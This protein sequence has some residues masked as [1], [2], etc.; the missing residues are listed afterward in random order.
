MEKFNTKQYETL[1]PSIAQKTQ[2]FHNLKKLKPSESVMAHALFVV[3]FGPLSTD[4]QSLL[5]ALSLL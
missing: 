4:H 2:F 1:H 3:S 5:I